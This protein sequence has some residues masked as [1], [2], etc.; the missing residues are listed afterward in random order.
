MSLFYLFRSSQKAYA[1]SWCRFKC[2]AIISQWGKQDFMKCPFLENNQKF[3][4]INNSSTKYYE[5]S[6]FR[7]VNVFINE[8]VS[9][10]YQFIQMRS[11]KT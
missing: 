8:G 2:Y 11:C 5:T 6:N 1:V 10:A 7:S 9:K 4:F 3:D